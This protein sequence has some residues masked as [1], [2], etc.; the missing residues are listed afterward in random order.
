METTYKNIPTIVNGDKVIGFTTSQI[1][2][3]KGWADRASLASW[4]QEDYS[5]NHI[6]MVNLF[7]NYTDTKIPMLKN[8]FDSKAVLEVNGMDGSFTYDVPVRKHNGTY[9]MKDTSMDSETPGIDESYFTVGLSR[10]FRPGDVLSYSEKY[11]EQFVVSE[12]HPV[13]QEGDYWLHT[14]QHNSLD[15]TKWFPAD[16]LKKGI[17][18]FKTGHILGEFS[19]QFSGISA[20]DNVGTM[21]CEFVLGN[22]RGVETSYTMYADKKNFSGARTETKNQLNYFLEE[23]NRNYRDEMGNNLDMFYMGNYNSA[24]G[25][26]NNSTLTIGS[27]LEFLAVLEN[28]KLEAHQLLFQKGGIIKGING[29]KRLNEGLWHQIRRG[30]KL[31]YSRPGGITRDLIRQAVAYVF[32]GRT[33]MLPMDRVIKFKAGYGA[34]MNMLELFREEAISQLSGLS[35]LLGTDSKIQSP[36]TGSLD[37]LK[38][39]TVAW[40]TVAIPDIGVIEVEYDPSLNY[41]MGS[42]RGTRGLYGKGHGQD[43]Y[44]LV[45][46]D[47]G[48][49]QSSNARTN[50]PQGTSLIEGGNAKSGIYYVKPQ[51]E[52]MWWGFEQGRWAP[53]KASDI[54][55]SSKTMSRE[56][57]IHSTSAAWVTDVSAYLVI[58]LK[59]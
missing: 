57:W 52:H 34:Y 54:M 9:T 6:G 43:S 11:G 59:R 14:V 28:T 53:N 36:V 35:Y 20:T 10:E 41:E 31:E 42:D 33:D 51:G 29:T 27:T 24:T 55:S 2:K 22:H 8:L 46:W 25:K 18:Y 19:T 45:I 40:K 58:E 38:L 44:S 37:M 21:T 56:F 47:A 32:Q 15:G 16:K 7:T 39:A 1:I 50:L 26:V 12:D 3:Q 13:I 4:Y 5:K 17:Q 49:P 48:S 23:Q 30:R